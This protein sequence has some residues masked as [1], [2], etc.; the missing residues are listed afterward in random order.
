M[1]YGTC[2]RVLGDAAEAG[3][4]P[5]CKNKMGNSVS[6]LDKASAMPVRWALLKRP[7]KPR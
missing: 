7:R 4:I 2:R 1:V 6:L 3:V 5:L